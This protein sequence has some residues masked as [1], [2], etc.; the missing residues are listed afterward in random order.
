MENYSV[1]AEF[2]HIEMLT[3]GLPNLGQV[4]VDLAPGSEELD[5]GLVVS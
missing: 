2:K 5:V 4:T 3:K 1:L